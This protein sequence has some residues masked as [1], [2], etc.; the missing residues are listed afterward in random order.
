MLKVALTGGIATGK[1]YVLNRLRERGVDTIDADDLVHRALERGSG[2]AQSVGEEFGAEFLTPDGDVDRT[3]LGAKVFADPPA[4]SRLEAIIHPYVYAEIGRWFA[5]RRKSM[6][7]ASIPLLFETNHQGDFDIV[8]ATHCTGAQQ[9]QRI[10]ERDRL[11]A[12]EARQRVSAQMPSDEKARRADFVISTS[13]TFADTDSRI[14]EV[15][16]AL[17]QRLGQTI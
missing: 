1:S 10:L 8:I 7:V 4:R 17:E 14:D 12:I 15:M 2:V 13:G 5:G 9:I 16:S 11:T 6:G 3:L